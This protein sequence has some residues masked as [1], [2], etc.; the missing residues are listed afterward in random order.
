MGKVQPLP[1]A[2]PKEDPRRQSWTTS[3][4]KRNVFLAIYITTFVV[5]SLCATV[6]SSRWSEVFKYNGHGCGHPPSGLV[7]RDTVKYI[8]HLRERYQI[9]GIALTVVHLP[10]RGVSVE[11]VG[12]KAS[13]A[14]YGF[15]EADVDGR[16][17]SN[18]VSGMVEVVNILC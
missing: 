11:S 16:A 4:R 5:I 7:K 6:P 12:E 9:P 1:V 15:G 14:F 17:V 3:K 10:E 18:Q 8:D 13:S 2:I